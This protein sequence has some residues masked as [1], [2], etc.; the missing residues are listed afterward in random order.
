MYVYIY[1]YI[2]VYMI[3]IYTYVHAIYTGMLDVLS[4]RCYTRR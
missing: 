1:A 4:G 2:H 3:Y